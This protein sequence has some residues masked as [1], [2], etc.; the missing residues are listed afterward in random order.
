MASKKLLLYLGLGTLCLWGLEIKNWK[1]LPPAGINQDTIGNFTYNAS[2][3]ENF[4]LKD[5]IFFTNPYATLTINANI[6]GTWNNQ[7]CGLVFCSSGNKYTFNKGNLV[8]VINSSTLNP[9]GELG[10]FALT[11]SATLD[12]NSNLS[13]NFAMGSVFPQAVFLVK[14]SV[15]NLE[16]IDLSI[17][18]QGHSLFKGTGNSKITI[19]AGG[20]YQSQ[21]VRLYGDLDLSDRASLTLKLGNRNSF[22]DGDIKLSGSAQ[23]NFVLSNSSA[24]ILNYA[25]AAGAKGKFEL[26]GS[27]LDAI[28][29]NAS[30]TDIS[31]MSGSVW[32]MQGDSQIGTLSLQE[33]SVDLK[34]GR[35][36]QAWV[37]RTLSA[38]QL[39]GGG[40]FVLYADIAQKGVDTVNLTQATGSHLAQM[41]YHPK[42]FTQDLA[43]SI[44]EADNM[45]VFEINGVDSQ[46]TFEGGVTEMGLTNYKTNLSRRINENKTQWV[47]SSI[48]PDGDSALSRVLSTA[49]NTPYR[50]F[51]VTSSTLALRLGDLRDYPKDHGLYAR[52]I[53]GLGNLAETKNT[54]KT[55]DVWM[56]FAGGY[57]AN[58]LYSNRTDFLG[59]GFEVSLMD[60]KN[61][62]YQS[63]TQAYGANLYYTSIFHNRFY[64]DVILKY[65][66]SPTS[67]EFA[68]A[69]NLNGKASLNAHLLTLGFEMGKKFGF[70]RAKNLFYLEPQGRLVSGVI[71]PTGLEVEDVYGERIFGDLKVQF[72]LIARASLYFGYE[73]NEGFRGDL[74]LGSFVEYSLN[75]GGE[76]VLQD[77]RSRLK[78]AF[79]YDLDVGISAMGSIEVE[80]FLRVYMQLDSAFL[81]EYASNVAFNMGVRW[82]FGDRYVPPP[83]PPADP[84]RFKIRYQRKNIQRTIPVVQ[85]DELNHMK[86]HGTTREAFERDYYQKNSKPSQSSQA[87]R[88]DIRFYPQDRYVPSYQSNPQREYNRGSKRDTYTPQYRDDTQRSSGRVYKR[89]N[90]R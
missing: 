20:N 69:N 30:G 32:Q 16:D 60:S 33:S 85:E 5:S 71:L 53:V 34:L 26:Y 54:F 49:L 37:K 7:S 44:T 9:Q 70:E 72:P 40:T 10:F 28:L 47:I 35:F 29:S 18:A 22:F 39:E 75:N 43:Q 89:D 51:D 57:D 19:N 15:L 13:V 41:F 84:E 6:S 4:V 55:Q 56:S 90:N 77:S 59:L 50:L 67:F 25:Q 8:F 45:V 2:G 42:T 17:D 86:Y 24:R 48:V 1:E 14:D 74:K 27:E 61:P 21:Q 81:G 64:Y 3:V 79:S 82:S 11:N 38:N 31:L 65:A 63:N 62:A 88:N 36:G 83:P 87:E 68:N 66:F 73:W 46:A 76:I 23:V 58:K 52:Y 12:I 80:K 78:K